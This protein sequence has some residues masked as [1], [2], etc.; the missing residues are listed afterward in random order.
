VEHEADVGTAI[1][2]P[3]GN[4]VA[5]VTVGIHDD[6]RGADR[7]P[8]SLIACGPRACNGQA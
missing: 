4:H 8:R 3:L 5:E 1:V 6:L 2:H 7:A